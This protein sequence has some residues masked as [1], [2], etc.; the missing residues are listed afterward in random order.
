MNASAVQRVVGLYVLCDAGAS[1]GDPGRIAAAALSAG[2][3]VLQL[4]AKGWD[5]DDT[6]RVGR[7]IV[8]RARACGAVVFA[9]DDPALVDPMD[10]D[11]VHLGALDGEIQSARKAMT[12]GRW[13]GRST[14]DVSGVDN[15]LL[16]GADVI[17]FGPVFD[18]GHASRPK[19]V[20][21][22]AGLREAAD[23]VLG[24]VP[25]VA[26]GG[27]N[28]HRLADVRAAGANSWAVISA[29]NTA[30]DPT[31]AASALLA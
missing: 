24:R 25:L 1:G 28:V 5:F 6:V 9:N 26:I 10:A 13:V 17:A 23:R 14:N 19:L 12:P 16:S 18:T 7:D 27:I 15:A 29:V 22:L 11:G 2:C 20:R 4:R 3:R 8:A 31:A 30:D 21:G